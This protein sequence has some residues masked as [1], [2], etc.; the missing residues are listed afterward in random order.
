MEENK[1]MLLEYYYKEK[2]LAP[3]F[4]LTIYHARIYL[5]IS[6]TYKELIMHLIQ[7]IILIN[8]GT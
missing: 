7:K 6:C 8:G 5:I 1:H 2:A 3:N 4:N